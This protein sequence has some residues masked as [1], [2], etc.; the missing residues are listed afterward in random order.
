KKLSELN[1]VKLPSG[2]IYI[3]RLGAQPDPGVAIDT[4]PS[5]NTACLIKTMMRANYYLATDTD[6]NITLSPYGNLINTIDG[7]GSPATDP[8]FY[9]VTEAVVTSATSDI[10]KQRSY[11]EIPGLKEGLKYFNDY[12]NLPN[13][14]IPN[15][16]GVII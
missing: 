12:N 14:E 5:S 15:L 7:S 16:Q 13:S 10:A 11:Y 6:G 1:P 4:D 3:K 9:Y 8:V 2:V